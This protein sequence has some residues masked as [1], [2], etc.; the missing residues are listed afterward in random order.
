VTASR[1]KIKSFFKGLRSEIF[2]DR[3]NCIYCD[4][5]LNTPNRQGV[6]DTCRPLLPY[7]T[8]ACCLKCGKPFLPAGADAPNAS[9]DDEAGYIEALEEEDGLFS[10]YC[11]MCRHNARHFDSVRSVFAYQ[12]VVRAAL[13]RL[14]YGDARY[15]APYFGAY[16]V[17]IYLADPTE[18]DLVVSVPLHPS[19]R[20][21]RG[22]NQAH[23]IAKDFAERMQLAYFPSALTKTKRTMSQT[24]LSFRDRQENLAGAFA[25]D[26]ALVKGKRVL[27]IDDVLTTG[28][29]MS[30][31]AHTLKRA[32]AVHVYGLTVANVAE[33]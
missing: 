6:C 7:I 26:K 16:L 25:S 30:E 31:V 27:V 14:K 33:R 3:Y 4:V 17:D 23:L 21:E 2:P 22:Y 12:G 11:A 8:G 1:D 13:Y 19:R 5:E 20:R 18:V 28:A 29:T 15:L 10:G 32:G 9:F 24:K